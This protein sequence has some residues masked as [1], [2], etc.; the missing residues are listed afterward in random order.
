MNLLEPDRFQSEL[1]KKIGKK[2][3]VQEQRPGFLH[4]KTILYF[5]PSFAA[6][7]ALFYKPFH[8]KMESFI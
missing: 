6:L 3:I 7:G 5:I 1:E 8:F 4:P 2:V